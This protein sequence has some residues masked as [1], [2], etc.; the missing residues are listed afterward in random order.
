MTE[1]RTIEE[2][3]DLVR[4][5]LAGSDPS[6]VQDVL[7]DIDELL[8][9]EQAEAIGELDEEALVAKAMA[10][11][12][13]PREVAQAYL[14]TEEKLDHALRSAPPTLGT[15]FFERIFGI[16]A[17]PQA[18]GSLLFMLLSLATGLI[19]FVWS[20]TGLA[21]TV[22]FSILIFGIPF[23]LLFVASLR[24]LALTEGRMV[25]ALLGIRMPRRPAPS[26]VEGSLWTR[27]RFWL[28]DRRTWTTLAYLL[29]KLPLGIVSF[30]FAI[31]LLSISMALIALPFAQLLTNLPLISFGSDVGVWL[32]WWSFPLTWLAAL[33][34]LLILLHGARIFGHLQGAMA[35]AMLVESA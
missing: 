18:Y 33:V 6:L 28:T 8:R 10:A 35:K 29:L 3:L 31:A 11:F 25:E 21:M 30:T 13:S 2:Y 27:I 34:D 22:G 9:S 19:Y 20:A 17:D 26:N 23:F 7:F 4:H 32:P 5:E 12:G 16:L 1:I 15:T 24:V 14:E